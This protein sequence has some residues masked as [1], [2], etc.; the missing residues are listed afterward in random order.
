MNLIPEW[1]DQQWRWDLVD[2]SSLENGANPAQT[3]V[4][5]WGV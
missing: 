1:L 5:L 3:W 2:F 4:P